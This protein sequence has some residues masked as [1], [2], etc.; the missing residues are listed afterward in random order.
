MSR[1]PRKFLFNKS[2]NIPPPGYYNTRQ[3]MENVLIDKM[4]KN[5]SLGMFNNNIPRFVENYTKDV[6]GPGYYNSNMPS[7]KI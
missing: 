3:T 4:L 6:P 2:E 1:I 5:S 7:F